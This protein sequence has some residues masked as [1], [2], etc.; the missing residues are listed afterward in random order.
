SATTFAHFGSHLVRFNFP[1][2]NVLRKNQQALMIVIAVLCIPFVFYFSKSDMSRVRHDDFGNLYGRS[3]PRIEALRNQRMFELARELG[4][5]TFLQDMVAGAQTQTQAYND[6]IWNRLILRHEAQRLGISSTTSEIVEVVKTLQPFRG[7]KGSFDRDK[8]TQF[9]QAL[10][11]AM[12]FGEGEIE[13]LV[14]DQ[15]ALQRMKD[16]VSSGVHIP[17]NESRENYDKAYGKLNV[18]VVRVRTDEIGKDVQISDEDVAKY[19]E[20]HKAELKSDEKRK[21]NLVS[22][23][24]NEEQKKLTG[25]ERVEVLQKLADSANDFTQGLLENGATFEQVAGKLQVP[26]QTSGDFTRRT[27][28]PLLSASPELTEAA[29]HLTSQE[30]NSD[31][32]QAGDGFSVLHLAGLEEA[33]P[34]SLEEARTQIVDAVRL[35][36]VRTL[37]AARGAVAAQKIR[38]LLKAGTAVDAALQQSG[39]PAEKIAPFALAD[40]SQPPT[41]P[42]KPLVPQAPDLGAIKNAVA[43]LKDGDV[44]DFI[45]TATGGVV[46]VLEKREPPDPAKYDLGRAAFNEQF[47][48]GKRDVAFQEWIRERRHEAGVPSTVEA[49]P[50]PSFG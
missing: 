7:E 12:G 48:K 24:L 17:E 29:F 10:L 25:K 14:G 18:S 50:E 30:P 46:A 3:V 26:V 42:G 22:F 39:L 2:I 35:Q 1:M 32:L 5:Y 44:T 8:Y 15:I 49:A 9:T 41:E 13:E 36:R 40:A 23:A 34:L 45:A 31:A 20:I 37:T 21:V 4:M 38:D 27:P 43:E 11:P 16:L 33:K 47:L 28:D 6:F 19:Y